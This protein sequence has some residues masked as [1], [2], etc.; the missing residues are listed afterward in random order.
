MSL[1]AKMKVI[2]DETEIEE[3][4]TQCAHHNYFYA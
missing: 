4:Y 1:L 3:V 2:V